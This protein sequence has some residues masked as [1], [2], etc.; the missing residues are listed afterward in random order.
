MIHCQRKYIVCVLAG[1][2]GFGMMTLFLP[3][4]EASETLT[5]SYEEGAS[6]EY[7][8]RIRREE[9]IHEENVRTIEFNFRCDGDQEKYDRA[10]RAE[11]K[12]HAEAVNEI[13]RDYR[14]GSPWR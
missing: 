7:D 13:E 3:S 11:Q 14:S 10:M 5:L 1:I 4:A 8:F 2:L 9:R 6:N 12:R